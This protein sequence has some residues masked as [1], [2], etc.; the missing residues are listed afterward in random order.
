MSDYT[1]DYKR[2]YIV[3]RSDLS[4]GVQSVQSSHATARFLKDCWGDSRLAVWWESQVMVNLVVPDEITLLGLGA[5]A[6]YL[7]ILAVAFQEPDLCYQVTAACF[8][9]S[10]EHRKLFGDLPLM[11]KELPW[12][13]ETPRT[14]VAAA[15]WQ[16][17]TAFAPPARTRWL[18]GGR[19]RAEL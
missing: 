14:V 19:R 17:T 15:D 6:N 2:L 3:T 8:L 18:Q 1:E 5:K 13:S 10:S 4:V 9:P 11:G 7:N 16:P 12:T